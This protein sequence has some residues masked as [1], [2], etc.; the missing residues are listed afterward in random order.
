MIADGKSRRLEKPKRK[1][2]KHLT[3]VAKAE[4]RVALKIQSGEKVSNGDIRKALAIF[5]AGGD[6]VDLIYTAN[7]CYYK[8]QVEKAGFME[9]TE[10]F[11]NKY[12]PQTMATLPES[13]WM[14]Q[15]IPS[16]RSGRAKF[17]SCQ[18]ML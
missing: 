18:Y 4:S 17:R 7:Y 1:K 15:R 14:Y 6:E 2:K 5:M 8:E 16:G 9:L 12:M 11:L 3:L 10:E 13:A